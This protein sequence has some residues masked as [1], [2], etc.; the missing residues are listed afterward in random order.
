MGRAGRVGLDRREGMGRGGKIREGK[1]RVN[2]EPHSYAEVR[3][4]DGK[5]GRRKKE[6][7]NEREKE[8]DE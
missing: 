4:W 8:Y 6:N 1:G 3:E 2:K 5:R 7:E